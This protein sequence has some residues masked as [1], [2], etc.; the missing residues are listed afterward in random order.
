[1]E[2][3]VKHMT[4]SLKYLILVLSCLA[5]T[6]C[7]KKP[8]NDTSPN[9]SQVPQAIPVYKSDADSYIHI[10]GPCQGNSGV[11]VTYWSSLTIKSSDKY[12]CVNDALTINLPVSWGTKSQL[13]TFEFQGYSNQKYSPAVMTTLDYNPLPPT[14]PGFAITSGGGVPSVGSPVGIQVQNSTIGEIWDPT[15]QTGPGIM[16]RSGLQGL[17]DP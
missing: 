7:F 9:F 14:V 17:L 1:M 12:N 13:F 5:L 4:P 10:I 8:G 15:T 11:R 16:S 6:A 3:L 2:E